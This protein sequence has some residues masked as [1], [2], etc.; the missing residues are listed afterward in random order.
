MLTYF[1]ILKQ[2]M[3]QPKFTLRGNFHNAHPVDSTNRISLLRWEQ[4][5]SLGK[6]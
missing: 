1:K 6:D 5:Y 2:S 4:H 3:I